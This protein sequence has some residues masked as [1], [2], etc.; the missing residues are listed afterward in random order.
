LTTVLLVDDEPSI[1]RF[2]RPALAAEGYDVVPANDGREALSL[3]AQRAPDVVIL[4]L[5]LPDIDG[6]VVLRRLRAW[7]D[8]PIVV[9]SARDREAEKV[10]ALDLWAD[11]FVNKPFG[12]GELCA[13]PCESIVRAG[14]PRTRS[15]SVA[16]RSTSRVI[17]YCGTEWT[18][19]S[20][21]GNSTFWPCSP[22]TPGP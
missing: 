10:E 20:R 7:S 12:V 6:K 11:D 2:L 15:A 22:A 8:V 17:G 1:H 18:S 13:P 4:D 5:G 16:A 9:L 14:R 3:A 21:A 19:I